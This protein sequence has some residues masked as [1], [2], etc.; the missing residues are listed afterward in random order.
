MCTVYNINLVS[1]SVFMSWI[2]KFSQ[3]MMVLAWSEIELVSVVV[4]VRRMMYVCFKAI[5]N[6]FCDIWKYFLELQKLI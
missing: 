3:S 6:S 1:E 5:Q 4:S 2:G